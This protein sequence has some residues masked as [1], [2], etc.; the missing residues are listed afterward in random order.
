MATL[1]IAGL[2]PY[3]IADFYA[4]LATASTQGLPFES[5]LQ[6]EF[7]TYDDYEV[8]SKQVWSKVQQE[9][10]LTTPFRQ[11]CQQVRNY[12]CPHCPAIP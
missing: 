6:V 10:T 11:V 7:G 5:S 3:G 12:W 2:D 4:R 9:C 1:F 8:R